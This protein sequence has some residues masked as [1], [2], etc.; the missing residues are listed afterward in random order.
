M[1][2]L[3]SNFKTYLSQSQGKSEKSL[4]YQH[5][6]LLSPQPITP[7]HLRRQEANRAAGFYISMLPSVRKV[8]DK[9]LSMFLDYRRKT[10]IPSQ[11]R[12]AEMLGCDI[13][14]VNS[15]VKKLNESGV[16]I[17]KSRGWRVK[18]VKNGIYKSYTCCYYLGITFKDN[19]RLIFKN[20]TAK[21][22]NIAKLFKAIPALRKYFMMFFVLSS[23]KECNNQCIYYNN[24][25][26]SSEFSFLI[27]DSYNKKENMKIL[28][29]SIVP[30]LYKITSV[31]QTN[32]SFFELS[33][34]PYT[35]SNNKDLSVIREKKERF[36]KR[37]SMDIRYCDNASYEKLSLK[38]QSFALRYYNARRTNRY[39]CIDEYEQYLRKINR[40]ELIYIPPE[41]LTPL[42]N[43]QRSFIKCFPKG[44]IKHVSERL[45]LCPKNKKSFQWICDTMNSICT[46]DEKTYIRG[47]LAKH[48]FNNKFLRMD[49]VPPKHAPIKHVTT[50]NLQDKQRSEVYGHIM[51]SAI[52]RSS[53]YVDNTNSFLADL[54]GPEA[55]RRCAENVER[56]NS[57]QT[58][59]QNREITFKQN[60]SSVG[61]SRELTPTEKFMRLVGEDNYMSYAQRAGLFEKTD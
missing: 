49:K 29:T 54:I 58:E 41:F 8:V 42:T 59:E 44:A 24:G 17:K 21:N 1:Q 45:M 55:A 46:Q 15:A 51:P 39:S 47:L 5:K 43:E 38:E 26:F 40:P 56:R 23:I 30:P 2:N 37:G 20:D 27:A 13:R 60:A 19:M 25:T 48:G 10:L 11:G 53:K 22:G 14:T 18:D 3:L 34:T 28:R 52:D 12:L 57:K 61:I 16:I 50:P 7:K 31:L 4:T 35:E 33:E 9:L 32:I 6:P 36:L